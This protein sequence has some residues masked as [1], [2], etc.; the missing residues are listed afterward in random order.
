MVDFESAVFRSLHVKFSHFPPRSYMIMCLIRT[1]TEMQGK[2]TATS[3]RD[4]LWALGVIL[5]RGVSEDAAGGTGL[6][7]YLDFANHGGGHNASCERGFDAQSGCHFLR[8][9]RDVHPGNVEFLL[10]HR[11]LF[12]MNAEDYSRLCSSCHIFEA[13]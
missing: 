9:V 11:N 1:G 4:F 13:T 5:S 2:P 7:P 6:V 8:A 10:L 3:P 12:P